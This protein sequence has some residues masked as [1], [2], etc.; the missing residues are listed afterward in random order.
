[1]FDPQIDRTIGYGDF[2]NRGVVHVARPAAPA[3]R[4]VPPAHL[5]RDHR[6]PAHRAR[7][8]R[9]ARRAAASATR[10]T[11]ALKAACAIGPFETAGVRGDVAAGG[12]GRRGRHGLGDRRQQPPRTRER[13][14]ARVRRAHRRAAL[15]LGSDSAGS[16]RSGVRDLARTAARSEPAPPTCG[17]V[18]A[19]DS[20]RGLVFVPTSSP[21][22]DYYGGE[23]LGEQSL[24]EL[25]RRACAP[26]TGTVA[27][28]FQTVHH[29]LWDY[30]NASPPA[31]VDLTAGGQRV[32]A[33]LQATKTGQL[34][35]LNRETGAPVFPVEERPVPASTIPGEEAW[36]TQPFTTVDSAA[37][38]AATAAGRRVGRGRHGTRGV[39]QARS[40]RCATK[41]SSRR[42]AWKA[43]SCCRR[44]SAA[45]TGAASR[46]IRRAR[47]PSC[48]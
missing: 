3:R 38:P 44:T 14:G 43:R 35:V 40:R 42:R 23:R 18:M 25:D 32:P 34:F 12:R 11:V 46:S 7:R 30:D 16:D 6:R 24:R 5:R 9:R 22:P 20:A 27:W 39:P 48:R 33:V 36:P 15:D 10:G 1:M 13:R 47:S 31:L 19:A 4:G 29:D 37:Q 8:A 45:R 28:H 2:T 26:P 41:A 17:R 21:A